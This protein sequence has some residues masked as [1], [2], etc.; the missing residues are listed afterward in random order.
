MDRDTELK[1]LL[2]RAQQRT[3]G[4][5]V[6]FN[7]PVTIIVHGSGVGIATSCTAPGALDRRRSVLATMPPH[8]MDNAR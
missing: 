4:A 3:D 2:S 1:A 7:A 6:V 8:K 5:Q